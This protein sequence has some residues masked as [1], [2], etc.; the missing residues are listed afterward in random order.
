MRFLPVLLLAAVAFPAATPAQTPS[1][2]APET[3]DARTIAK[4][5]GARLVSDFV[6]PEQGA[7]Y[8]A[9]LNANADA[10]VYDALS[11]VELAARLGADLQKVAADGHL[12]VM[13]Q[14]LG[15]GGGPQIVV[16]RP[17]D[18]AEGVPPGDVK[19]VVMRMERPRAM[20]QARWISPGIA[21]VR[22]NGFPGGPEIMTAVNRF[23]SD[24]AK[25][26]VIIFDLRTHMGG[27]LDEMDAIFPWLYAKPTRLLSMAARKSVDEAGMSPISDVKT[28]RLVQGDA[29][30]VIR[31]HW[32]KPGMDKSLNR[33]KVYVL[34]SG[35]SASA[36][37]HFALALQHTGR[38]KLIGRTTYGANHFGG[39]QDLGGGFTAFIPVGRAY[40]PKTGKDWEGTGIAPDIDVPAEDALVKA[41]TLSGM[42][43]V[44]ATKLSTEVAPKGPMTGRSM[45]KAQP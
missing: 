2:V 10:G 1:A 7:R 9:M 6:Y 40:N 19:P 42:P 26:K 33:A 5:L 13:Y 30:F 36:A 43:L 27:G 3:L 4:N 24:H 45:R 21:F 22:F 11:G 32:V 31:E 16:R 25:A 29:E 12:R 38:A 37:E 44:K 17:P 39:D 8:A 14:G 23:M 35:F 18:G 41:L 28:L 20:E 34:T 15:G